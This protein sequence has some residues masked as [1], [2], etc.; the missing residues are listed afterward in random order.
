MDREAWRAAVHGVAKSWTW[1]TDW[2]EL[3]WSGY[4]LMWQQST[5]EFPHICDVLAG[6]EQQNGRNPKFWMTLGK[7]E[8]WDCLL[9]YRRQTKPSLSPVLSLYSLFLASERG[10]SNMTHHACCC[11]CKVA[12]VVS[13]SMRPH[14]W[15]PTRLPHPWDSP[16][17]NSNLQSLYLP[18][19]YSL[20]TKFFNFILSETVTLITWT[21]LHRGWLAP[22]F[23]NLLT[24]FICFKI[25]FLHLPFYFILFFFTNGNLL[26]KKD[27]I[28]SN[29]WGKFGLFSE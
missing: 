26:Y 8:W 6:T 3:N 19:E 24:A 14:R 10:S 7:L 17:K 18:V 12:S 15:Q 28:S 11:C 25:Y 9:S 27:G 4:Q 20:W 5:F 16:D 21:W 22:T 29:Q 23:V 1:Q 2:T 13:D